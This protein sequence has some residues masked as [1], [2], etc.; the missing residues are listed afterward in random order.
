MTR[1]PISMPSW[2]YQNS[3][4]QPP[5]ASNAVRR[6]NEQPSQN[7]TTSPPRSGSDVRSL[8][9][10]RRAGGSP[11]GATERACTT[12]SD[13]SPSNDATTRA[14]ASSVTNSRSSSKNNR[15]SPDT[16]AA[17]MLRPAGTPRLSGSAT[18]RTPAGSPVGVQPFPTTTTSTVTS[19][20]ESSD[21]SARSSSSGRLPM[22]RTT[23]PTESISG[24]SLLAIGVGVVL[25]EDLLDRRV[26]GHG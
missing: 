12:A 15:M 7:Q 20:W 25:L 21:R 11:A 18:E 14:M 16:S 5:A 26:S 1:Q 10:C 8:G 24:R 4:A 22:L 19:R 6:M 3:P 2:P 17:P 23:A 9:T 13:T